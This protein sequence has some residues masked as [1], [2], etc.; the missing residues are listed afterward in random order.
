MRLQIKII[1]ILAF[2]WMLVFHVNGQDMVYYYGSNHKP[3]NSIENARF[4]KKLYRKTRKKTIIDTYTRL[5]NDWKLAKKEKIRSNQNGY[6]VI[7]VTTNTIYPDKIHRKFSINANGDFDFQEYADDKLVRTGTTSRMLPLHLK[8]TITEYFR[9]GQ[10]KAVSYYENNSLISNQTW[11]KDGTRYVED[12]FYSVDEIPEY[13]L[14]PQN[15]QT[16]VMKSLHAENVDLSQYSGI[17]TLGW[18]IKENGELLG[19]HMLA[20]QYAGL[21]ELL[22]DIIEDL[23]GNWQPARLDGQ[24]VNY[25][26]K[27]PVN[28]DNNAHLQVFDG[29]EFSNGFLMWY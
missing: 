10:K 14:G 5:D 3:V 24:K 2:S 7:K 8:D 9:N 1:F 25:F 21:G 23:P 22:S 27:F 17:I 18:V 20:G 26:M 13:T 4:I 12:L 29:V 16:F 28:F 15:F 6:Q 11:L 19:A